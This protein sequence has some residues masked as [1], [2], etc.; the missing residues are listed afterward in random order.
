MNELEIGLEK[1]RIAGRIVIGENEPHHLGFDWPAER[2]F[3]F[4]TMLVCK[5]CRA[6][7]L[8]AI[9]QWF[10]SAKRVDTDGANI[11]VRIDGTTRMLTRE[12]FEI[13]RENTKE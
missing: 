10:T 9:R 8:D 7:W 1:I 5:H 3:N 12:E 2:N 13:Y 4:F 6:E 11:P